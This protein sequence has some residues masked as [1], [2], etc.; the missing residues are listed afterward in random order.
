MD[1]SIFGPVFAL[2]LLTFY[3]TPRVAL[4]RIKAAKEGRVNPMYYK[5]NQGFEQPQEVAVLGRHYNNLLEMPILFYLWSIIVFVT[6][7]TSDTMLVFGWV[8]VGI[9]FIHSYIHLGPNKIMSRIRAFAI[10]YLVLT[11]AWLYLGYS[12]YLA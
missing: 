8:Y 7:S 2:V 11:I 4:A 10:S 6:G 9:R 1:Y 12:L 5:A 3:V